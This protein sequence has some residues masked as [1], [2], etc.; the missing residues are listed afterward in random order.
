MTSTYRR[1]DLHYALDG[2]YNSP[3]PDLVAR[4]DGECLFYRG[5]LHAIQGEPESAKW[6]LA[7]VAI[8]GAI[9]AGLEAAC[10]DPVC[11]AR[12]HVVI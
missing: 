4:T 3:S 10:F 2:S 8:A 9:D 7:I 6:W 12:G 11:S 1:Q 5:C